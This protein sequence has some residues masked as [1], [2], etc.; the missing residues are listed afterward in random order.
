MQ[1]AVLE[2]GRRDA[3]ERRADGGAPGEV[4]LARR[5]RRVAQQLDERAR[6]R[7]G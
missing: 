6:H 5:Q 7:A 3:L 1:H 4:D 2:R